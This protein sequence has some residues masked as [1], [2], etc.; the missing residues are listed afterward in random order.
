L[1]VVF[2]GFSVVR[3]R[4]YAP[5]LLHLIPRLLV[6]V[7]ACA[8]S[9]YDILYQPPGGTVK[10]LGDDGC[11]FQGCIPG[12]WPATCDGRQTREYHKETNSMITLSSIVHR[13]S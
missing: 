12:V 9:G 6:L 3:V 10:G 2:A 4:S 5:T 1:Q 7:T 8:V 11:Y 13:P